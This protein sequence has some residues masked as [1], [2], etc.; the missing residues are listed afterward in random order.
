MEN[1][2]IFIRPYKYWN[3]NKKYIFICTNGKFFFLTI[4]EQQSTQTEERGVPEERGEE[5][6]GPYFPNCKID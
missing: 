2:K 6:Q 4:L 5:R 1:Y 3:Y